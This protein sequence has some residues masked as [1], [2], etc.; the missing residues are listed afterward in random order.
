VSKYKGI[1][2]VA[3]FAMEDGIYGQDSGTTIRLKKV[4]KTQI[5]FATRGFLFF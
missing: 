4:K 1:D 3:Y 5:L 2:E